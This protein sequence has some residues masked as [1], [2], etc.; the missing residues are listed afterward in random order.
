MAVVPRAQPR[1]GNA[2]RL[3][4]LLELLRRLRIS[5]VLVRVQQARACST[6]S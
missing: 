6:P 2:V 3:E 5:G 4:H 1:V